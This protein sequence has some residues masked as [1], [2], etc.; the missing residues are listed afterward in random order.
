[1]KIDSK[2]VAHLAEEYETNESSF[3]KFF[4]RDL[5]KKIAVETNK[6]T[7]VVNEINKANPYG[8]PL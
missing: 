1:M 8:I 4:C 7:G 6:I 3:V 2:T 5:L